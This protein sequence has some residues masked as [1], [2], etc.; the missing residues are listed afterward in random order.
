MKYV[1]TDPGY[2]LDADDWDKFVDLLMD[3]KPESEQIAFFKE[4]G[5]TALAISDTGFGDW[6][7]ELYTTGCYPISIE[8][9]S[10]CA[11][12]G[13]VGVFE[14]NDKVQKRVDELPES[15]CAIFETDLDISV[16]MDT[17]DPSWTVVKIKNGD[18]VIAA[19]TDYTDE[20]QDEEDEE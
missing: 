14:V 6:S 2:L 4:H 12:A 18:N 15:C 19:S 16:N 8:Q 3:C 5:I 11:D 20:D 13:M 1:V 7:N 17:L 9:S 10:F